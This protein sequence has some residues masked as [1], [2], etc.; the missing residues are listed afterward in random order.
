[1]RQKK[2]FIF[3]VTIIILAVGI[4]G[5][6]V[7]VKKG[8]TVIQQAS[9]P[10]PAPTQSPVTQ[11]STSVQPDETEKWETYRNETYGFGFKYPPSMQISVSEGL[12]MIVDRQSKQ[13][14]S[15]SVDKNGNPTERS[16]Q[17]LAA[18]E[19]VGE[20]YSAYKTVGGVE[21]VSGQE[22]LVIMFT[23][24]KDVYLAMSSIPWV[25]QERLNQKL[26]DQILSTLKFI[27]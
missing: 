7:L 4:V 23:K 9:T 17:S 19:F 25:T 15:V 5:Y 1:M 27:Q 26:F 24:G 10:T 3:I 11:P 21:A 2:L 13:G 6:F 12:V 8:E 20:K 14:L 22:G 18:E 16:I